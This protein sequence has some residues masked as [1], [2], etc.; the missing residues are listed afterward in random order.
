MALK[1]T[2]H[3]SLFTLS[4]LQDETKES[5]YVLFSVT[6]FCYFLIVLINVTLIF[7]I[8]QEKSLHEPMYIF[9]CNLCINGLYG[10][11]GFYPKFLYDLLAEDH[12]ISYNGCYLQAF[13]IYS[14]F[15]CDYSILTVMAYDRNVAICRPLEYHSVMTN[16]I[17]KFVVFP[18]I[19]PLFCMGI[20][21][22]LSHRLTLCGSKIEKLYCAN[23]PIVRLSCSSNTLDS[24]A[25]YF[26]IVVYIIHILF[27]VYSYIN[28][29]RTC[30]N[31]TEN[32]GKFL[33][34]CLP[35]LFSLTNVTI[36]IL[37]ELMHNRYGSRDL[38]RRLLNFLAME[39]LVIPPLLNPL[40]YGLQL[41]KIRRTV[42]G[43]CRKQNG[44]NRL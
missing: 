25:G 24:V 12:V 34:T 35:H 4:G 29:I 2:T 11:I 3:L 7:I 31:S 8:L 44:V 22:F 16:Q 43:K 19:P 28:L 39:F 36:A 20:L 42:L 23:W 21:M 41:T 27:I 10:T 26:V 13:V 30:L 32:R 40:I 37:F 6:L 17:V 14:N 9:L 1:N 38:P 18:W 5:R 15:L 33:Q